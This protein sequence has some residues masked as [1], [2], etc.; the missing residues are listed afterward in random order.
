MVSCH[1]LDILDLLCAK[2][3]AHIPSSMQTQWGKVSFFWT[4]EREANNSYTGAPQ[5]PG[6]FAVGYSCPMPKT[7]SHRLSAFRGIQWPSRGEMLVEC[8]SGSKSIGLQGGS[9][10]VLKEK[11]EKRAMFWNRMI[12]I[13]RLMLRTKEFRRRS[14]AATKR[15][16]PEE[17]CLLNRAANLSFLVYVYFCVAICLRKKS[18][19]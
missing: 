11:R 8:G 10:T 7:L 1:T 9:C 18:T 19:F 12:H 17:T 2:V 16:K 15:S 14:G 13:Y 6:T 4:D 3:Y 5:Y